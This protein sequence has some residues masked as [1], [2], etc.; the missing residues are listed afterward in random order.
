MIGRKDHFALNTRSR[1]VLLQRDFKGFGL[2]MC[3]IFK[4]FLFRNICFEILFHF[5]DLHSIFLRISNKFHFGWIERPS[6]ESRPTNHTLSSSF[7]FWDLDE[8]LMDL[9]TSFHSLRGLRFFWVCT[10]ECRSWLVH[11]LLH[12]W[13]V[14]RIEG[15]F[16]VSWRIYGVF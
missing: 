13:E 3:K 15:R 12:F 14:N 9:R 2:C 10:Y 8:S 16:L 4:W 6:P 7:F 1:E 11:M 5:F